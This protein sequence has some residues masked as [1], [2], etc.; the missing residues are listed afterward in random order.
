MECSP[1]VVDWTGEHAWNS[2]TVIDTCHTSSSRDCLLPLVSLADSLLR[3]LNTP[4]HPTTDSAHQS[5][6][7]TQSLSVSGMGLS[8]SD[9]ELCPGTGPLIGSLGLSAEAMTTTL[10][11]S[12]ETQ[13]IGSA[14][15]NMTSCLGKE[16][17]DGDCEVSLSQLMMGTGVCWSTNHLYGTGI[18]DMNRGGSVLCLNSSFVSC[19]LDATYKN[20]SFTTRTN[21]T[22][23]YSLITFSFCTFK[24]CTSTSEGGAIYCKIEAVTIQIKGCSFHSCSSSSWGG[25]LYFTLSSLSMS[26]SLESSSFV[27]CYSATYGGSVR[28]NSVPTISVAD[29]A[30][31]DSSAQNYGGSLAISSWDADSSYQNLITNCLFQNSRQTNSSSTYGGGGIYF[32]SCPSVKLS[33]LQ[34]RQCSAATGKGHDIYVSGSP[35]TLNANT[36]SNCDS[37]TTKSNYLVYVTNTSTDRSNLLS[38]TLTALRIISLS[39]IPKGDSADLVV[40]VDKA[41]TG[42]LLVLI[43]NVN[44]E[45]QPGSGAFPNIVI[46][47]SLSGHVVSFDGV[48]LDAPV[49]LESVSCSL[50]E[51]GTTATITLGGRKLPIGKYKV[52]LHDGW[53]FEVELSSDSE[54]FVVGSHRL[55]EIGDGTKWKEQSVWIVSGMECVSEPSIDVLVRNTTYFTIPVV[56]SKVTGIGWPSLNKKKTEVS[57]EIVGSGFP[58]SITSVSL[59]RGERTIASSSASMMSSTSISVSFAARFTEDENSCEFGA[60]YELSTI[61][62][63]KT[64]TVPSDLSITIPSP[65]TLTSISCPLSASD[66]NLVVLTV[67]G[68]NLADGQYF[69]VVQKGSEP[70]ITIEIQIASNAGAVPLLAFGSGVLEYSGTYS[71]TRMWSESVDALVSSGALSF[72]VDSAPA[73]IESVLCVLSDDSEKKEA[74]L[75]LTGSSLP[76]DKLITITIQQLSSVGQIVGS[77]VQLDMYA[78][79]L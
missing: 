78:Q 21:I 46:A 70:S 40:R 59:K 47:A 19:T 56:P 34:F 66:A 30:F 50:D 4:S 75:T 32:N 26:V 73:R 38:S 36:V 41:M 18:V 6:S 17:A 64:I 24:G 57:F 28:F 71:V 7:H 15:H 52:I 61:A 60:T 22:S 12:I 31:L 58:L 29:C 77:P 49:V 25:A 23:Q 16:Q 51:S 1:L 45:R 9:C 8:L 43:S 11:T 13:L 69:V 42:K 20:K 14:L 68:E 5:T 76:L 53:F 72:T 55:D 54:G 48:E 3:S 27:G 10:P 62:A 74:K 67:G 39:A 79:G 37:Q 33:F 35:P 63:S 65:P 44:G 2:I